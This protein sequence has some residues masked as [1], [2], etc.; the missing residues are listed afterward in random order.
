MV[1]SHRITSLFEEL[2]SIALESNLGNGREPV[3][4]GTVIGKPN[5]HTL[6]A[7]GLVECCHGYYFLTDKGRDVY[8]LFCKTP[9]KENDYEDLKDKNHIRPEGSLHHRLVDTRAV[10]IPDVAEGV[11]R[12]YGKTDEDT[13]MSEVIAD[14]YEDVLDELAVERV[15]HTTPAEGLMIAIG[16]L[17]RRPDDVQENTN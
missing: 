12:G 11:R 7:L 6:V 3:W 16:W 15:E 13:D 17:V 10:S 14:E 2:S 8:S 4:D 9:P 1:D 5:Q